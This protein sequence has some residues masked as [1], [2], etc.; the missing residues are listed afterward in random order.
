[1]EKN[2]KD[3]LIAIV[4]G[5]EDEVDGNIDFIGLAKENVYHIDCLIDYGKKKYPGHKGFQALNDRYTVEAPIFYLTCLDNAVYLNIP[6]EKIGKYGLLYLPDELSDAQIKSLHK[7]AKQIPRINL[8]ICYNMRVEDGLI[9]YDNLDDKDSKNFE[10][11]LNAYE[12]EIKASKKS[13]N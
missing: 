1:M 8:E 9:Q 3:Y 2:I 7:L 5:P 13:L 4:N 11:M 12:K 10:D 6:D